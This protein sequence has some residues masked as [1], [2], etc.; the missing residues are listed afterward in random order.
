MLRF[1]IGSFL[2]FQ[3]GCAKEVCSKDKGCLKTI[4]KTDNYRLNLEI[5]DKLKHLV[6][7]P[8][9]KKVR[10]RIEHKLY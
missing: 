9:E 7:C 5:R 8:E 2:L 10:T 3:T 4:P 1:L 6:C